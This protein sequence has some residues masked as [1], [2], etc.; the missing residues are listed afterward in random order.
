MDSL[1]LLRT[2]TDKEMEHTKGELYF[3]SD[4]IY[5]GNGDQIANAK[6]I[7]ASPLLLEALLDIMDAYDN[8]RKSKDEVEIDMA[9]ALDKA[10]KAIKQATL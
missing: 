6:L 3:T 9:I 2:K 1:I 7:A 4:G 10:Q 5:D 8:S